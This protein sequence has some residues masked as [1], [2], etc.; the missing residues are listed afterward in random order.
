MS[1][2]IVYE[3]E[4]DS[5]GVLYEITVED[6]EKNE[7]VYCPFCGADIDIEDEEDLYDEL[8]YDYDED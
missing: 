2:E 6:E 8:D 1:D 4:C 7:P 5:C 3:L